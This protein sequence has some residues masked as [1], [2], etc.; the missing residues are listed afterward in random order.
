MIPEEEGF[1][2]SSS[3]QLWIAISKSAPM[4]QCFASTVGVHAAG[5][6]SRAT[7][8]ALGSYL[9]PWLARGA[10]GNYNKGIYLACKSPHLAITT[11]ASGFLGLMSRAWEAIVH[12]SAALPTRS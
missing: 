2:P 10:G 7:K 5:P 1:Y 4:A 9:W 3:Q 12:A 11:S 6:H 8:G